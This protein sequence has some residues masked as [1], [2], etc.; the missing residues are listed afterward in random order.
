MTEPTSMPNWVSSDEIIG[1][2]ATMS[3]EAKGMARW[4]L[5]LLRDFQ[6]SLS[7][8]VANNVRQLVSSLVSEPKM[9][10]AKP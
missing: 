1:I 2:P 7:L 3:A 9:P 4:P 8:L 6:S 10:W 5:D